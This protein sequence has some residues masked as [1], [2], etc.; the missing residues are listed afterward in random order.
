MSIVEKL[1]VCMS[2]PS[3]CGLSNDLFQVHPD[4]PCWLKT[5]QFKKSNWNRIKMV[6][7]L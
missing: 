7:C 3:N 5:F 1:F 2:D 4:G 6:D